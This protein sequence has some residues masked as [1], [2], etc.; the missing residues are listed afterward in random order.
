MKTTEE[1][2]TALHY[3]SFS[4]NLDAIYTLLENKA[5]MYAQNINKL[6]MLHVA[7]QGD[8]PGP[9]YLF[10]MLGLNLNTPDKRGSTPLLWACYS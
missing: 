2:W 7:C 1:Q 3:A 10:K 6:N 8:N 4:G 5:D 9:L